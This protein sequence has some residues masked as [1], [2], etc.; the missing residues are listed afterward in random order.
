VESFIFGHSSQNIPIVGH[1]FGTVGLHALVI[2]GV[3]GDEVEGVVASHGLLEQ[4][5]KSF[6]LPLRV[7]LIPIFN[8]DGVLKKERMNARGVDLNRNLPTKD[9]SPEATTPRY[10]PGPKPCSEPEN[11]ALVAFLEKEKPDFICSLHSWK[12]LLNINGD[13]APEAEAMA[14]KT[15]YIITPTIGYSTPGCLGTYSGIE[16]N[17]PTLTYEIERG[18]AAGRVLEIHV[19]AVIEG[20]K[21]LARRN[22]RP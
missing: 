9:W 21:A 1:R 11:Q 14:S 13:C 4:W 18:L 19:P 8:M 7:T 20:L 22:D 2:G 17:I 16:R 12:P 6:T 10:Q 5:I 15:G 3:H